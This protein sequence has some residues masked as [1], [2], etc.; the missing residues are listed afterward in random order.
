MEFTSDELAL[1]ITLAEHE[2]DYAP[3][4]T[5]IEDAASLNFD[6]QAH[7]EKLRDEPA[8]LTAKEKWFL[9][10]LFKSIFSLITGVPW[11]F[12]KP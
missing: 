5:D 1:F 11:P 12:P 9:W 2:T 8:M 3:T 4:S 7:F 10:E 6:I